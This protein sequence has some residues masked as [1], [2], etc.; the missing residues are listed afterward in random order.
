MDISDSFLQYR[1]TLMAGRIGLQKHIQV[2]L[3]GSI[4]SLSKNQT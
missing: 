1:A 3:N 4:S 2:F